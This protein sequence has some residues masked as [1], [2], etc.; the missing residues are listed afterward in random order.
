MAHLQD[1]ARGR[2]LG[3]SLSRNR[4]SVF[5]ENITCERLL[6]LQS[7]I[8]DTNE[9]HE[10]GSTIIEALFNTNTI[11]IRPST[12]FSIS[13]IGMKRGSLEYLLINLASPTM[14]VRV[15]AFEERC[16]WSK[17]IIFSTK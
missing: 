9:S 16:S 13:T 7:E 6:L 2:C 3:R 12:A 8:F 14:R 1:R 11:K 17:S 4:A 15:G 5:F 10:I